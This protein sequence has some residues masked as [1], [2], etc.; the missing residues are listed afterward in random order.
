MGINRLAAVGLFVVGGLL[1]FS[2]GLFF[3]GERRMLFGNTF[4]VFAEF[5][6]IAGLQ[7]GAIVRVA[8]MDAGE[9]ELIQVPAGPASR[10]RVRMRI[11]NDLHPLIREDSV[12]SIQSDGLVGNKF[13]QIEPGTEHAA[14]VPDGGTILSREPFDFADIMDQLSATIQTVNETI[15]DVRL[16]LDEALNS[17]SATARS[18][19]VLLEDVGGDARAIMTVGNRVSKDLAGI[20]AGVREGKG[21]IGQLLT[22]D[23]LYQRAKNIAAEAERAMATV[24][25]ATEEARAAIADLRGT[26][27][28]VQG[29]TGDLQQTLSAAR[30]AM[31]DLADSTEALKRNFLLRGF[32]NRR[33]YFDLDDLTVQQYRNG[34]LDTDDRR[35]LRVWLRADVV[36]EKDAKGVERLSA[37]G[38]ARLDSAMAV[39]VKYPKTSPFVIEGYAGG[40]TADERFLA[41]QQRARLVRDYLV[42][43]F[44]LDPTVVATMPMGHEAESAPDGDTWNGVAL[45]MFVPVPAL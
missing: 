25:Q 31:N 28:P 35:P 38:R 29:L 14:I 3:I 21:T 4:E 19:E 30:D 32:F 12:A 22:D 45:V 17:I 10:F 2:V 24:R 42:S 27:G 7:N 44:G 13:V 9:V 18:A 23:T 1:L 5:A 11:R 26:D 20:V 33:G 15:L 43:K 36:F 6:G 16:E 40:L 8:G 37:G 41:S 34:A 39:F